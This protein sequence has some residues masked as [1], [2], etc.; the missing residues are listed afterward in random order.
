MSNP[1]LKLEVLKH[2]LSSEDDAQLVKALSIFRAENVEFWN[3]LTDAQRAEVELSRKQV[4]EGKV[5]DW[6]AVYQR[7]TEYLP[8]PKSNSIH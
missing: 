7:L 5:E 4:L 6:K 2:V 3:E 1:A 8:Y